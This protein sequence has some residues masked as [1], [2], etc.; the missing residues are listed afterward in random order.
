MK[1]FKSGK[2][3]ALWLLRLSLMPVLFS[4]YYT[5]VSTW[6]FKNLSFYISVFMLI[7]GA[8]LIIS[9][10]LSKPLLTVIS[11]LV[12][13]CISLYK[14]YITFNGVIDMYVSMHLIP[15]SLGFFFFTNGNET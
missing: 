6:N 8:V 13:F 3:I 10:F 12:I 14:V 11:G 4:I 5:T 2:P 7:S 1:P 15:L 9:G